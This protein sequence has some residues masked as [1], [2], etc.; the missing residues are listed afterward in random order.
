MERLAAVKL[1]EGGST[2]QV[3]LGR[4]FLRHFKMVYDGP[5]GTVSISRD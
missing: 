4:T 1:V 5:A 3:L 2:F